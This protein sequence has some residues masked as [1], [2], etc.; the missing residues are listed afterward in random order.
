MHRGFLKNAMKEIRKIKRTLTLLR[1]ARVKRFCKHYGLQYVGAL[2]SCCIV[3]RY[4]LRL[5]GLQYYQSKRKLSMG[6]VV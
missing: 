2:I 5:G 6:N 4:F 3:C 1:D